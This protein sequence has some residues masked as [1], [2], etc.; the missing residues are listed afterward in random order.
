MRCWAIVSLLFAFC[1]GACGG[2]ID[3]GSDIP[4]G[5]LPVDE[6]NPVVL[7]NDSVYDNWQ[8]EYAMLFA[9]SGGPP[10]AGIIVGTSPNWTDLGVN[11]VG[12]RDLVAAA[13]A[14][15]LRNIPD[16]T[17]STGA[18]LKR[19]AN[20]D[21]D[22]TKPNIS[23]GAKAIVSTSISMS[24]PSR[25]MVVVTGGRLT[26]VA[27]AYL[28]DHTVV[29]RVVVVSSLGT[30]TAS[31]GAMGVPNGEMDPWA[32]AIVLTKF[33]YIQV[34]AYYDQTTDVPSS[35]F[36]QLPVNAFGDWIQA[37]ST[38]IS[39]NNLAADQVSIIALGL[40]SFVTEIESLSQDTSSDASSPDWPLLRPDSAGRA[41]LV[42][43]SSGALAT[44]RFWQ[45]LLDPA[46]YGK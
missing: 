18:P 12:W 43:R 5:Q 42:T 19:P 22:A 20:G 46:T 33:R 45:L 32:D 8:G 41:T 21:I 40:P 7:V 4:Q 2:R 39:R 36:Q 1:A 13:R 38:Q 25:P 35:L 11:V 27:D 14:S 15:G 31:G 3:A 17:G 30:V 9:N 28:I 29:D 24:R 26:D 44:S 23:E 6:R 10:I 16:P 37:K 34:S